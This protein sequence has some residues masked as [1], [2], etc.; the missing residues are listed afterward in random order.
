MHSRN[1]RHI[2]V[3]LLALAFATSTYAR[4]QFW[5]FLGSVHVKNGQDRGV[6]QI[7]R[8]NEPFHAIQLRVSGDAIFF[9][10]LIVHFGDGTS[11]EFV[12]SDRISAEGKSYVVELHDESRV[13]EN[14]E[15]RYYKQA[16]EHSPKIS[17]YG[18]RPQVGDGVS[19]D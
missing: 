5:D 7:A 16:W 18:S 10:R 8:H 9:D 6:I 17:L 12:V 14:I 4:G 1:L 13:L 19:K 2:T 15:L 11:E 3:A